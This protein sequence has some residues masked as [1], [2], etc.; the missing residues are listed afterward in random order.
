MFI[1][2][3]KVF[4]SGIIISLASLLS[5]K[6]PVLAGFLIALPL[7]SIISLIF[8]YMEHKNFEKTIV[9]A[10][11]ILIGVPVS[12]TFFI[13]FFFAKSLGLNFYITYILGITFL[14]LGYFLHKLLMDQL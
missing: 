11:S 9:F 6:K 5:S 2:I 12:L 3:L 14:I 13:P 4:F 8:S 10:K 7:M 1:F